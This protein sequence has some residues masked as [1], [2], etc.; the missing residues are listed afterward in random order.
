MAGRFEERL[1]KPVESL[2]SIFAS[3]AVLLTIWFAIVFAIRGVDA[4]FGWHYGFRSI[5]DFLAWP[6][7]HTKLLA[8]DRSF[9]LLAAAIAGFGIANALQEFVEWARMSPEQRRL[10]RERARFAYGKQQQL[11]WEQ[12]QARKADR[13]PMSGW[14]R[15]WLVL[16]VLFGALAFW[17]AHDSYSRAWAH[18]PWNGDNKAFWS[19]AH[20]NPRLSECDW[21]TAEAKY[22]IGHEYTVY[23]ETRYPFT[24]ALP[25]AFVPALFMAAVGLAIRWIYR[26]FRQSKGTTEET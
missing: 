2:I 26:G 16:S 4:L 14:R 6:R 25:W 21:S 19:A 13:K 15:L 7:P 3:S 10:E 17:I 1:I 5:G 22:P 9:L 23:C 20:S 12:K 8:L 11:E 24:R 18:V